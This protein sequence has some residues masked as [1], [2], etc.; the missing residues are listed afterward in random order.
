MAGRTEAPHAGNGGSRGY[1]P[2]FRALAISVFNGGRPDLLTCSLA[3]VRRWILQNQRQQQRGNRPATI[4]RGEDFFW[5]AFYRKA[6]PK[7]LADEII[8]FIARVSSNGT[9]YSRPDITTAEKRLGLSRKVGATTANQAMLPR[10]V[11]RRTQF[12]SQP[13]PYGVNGVLRN[14]L[15]DIDEAAITLEGCNRKYG[16][17]AKGVLVRQKGVYGHGD[18]FTIICAI[19]PEGVLGFWIRQ[20]AGTTIEDFIN[21]MQFQ[22]LSRLPVNGP[23]RMFMYDNL[24]SH[25]NARIGNLISAAGHRYIARPSYR[26][27]DA[28][29]EYAFNQLQAELRNRMYQINT[30]A[31]LIRECTNIV[32]GMGNFDLLFQRC[33]Y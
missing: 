27:Q 18:K 8:T 16:K 21:F 22:P 33:G 14:S 28:P 7:A 15:I 19:G 30:P 3:S 11:A 31:D 9:V 4:L 5:L 26:P 24:S 1:G 6:Y 13:W 12:W 25:L 20:V 29:I 2:E 23:R 10:N 17:A 32:Q